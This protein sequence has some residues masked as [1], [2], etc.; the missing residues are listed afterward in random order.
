MIIRVQLKPF[1]EWPGMCGACN[2]TGYE[3]FATLEQMERAGGLWV[4]IDTAKPANTM[5]RSWHTTRESVQRVMD[6]QGT[7]PRMVVTEEDAKRLAFCEHM[8]EPDSFFIGKLFARLHRVGLLKQFPKNQLPVKPADPLVGKFFLSM[9]RCAGCGAS[10]MDGRGEVLERIPGADAYVVQPFAL[11]PNLIRAS[12]VQR[13]Q[14]HEMA[15]W[16][17]YE[18]IPLMLSDEKELEQR[19]HQHELPAHVN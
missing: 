10:R 3:S 9:S 11:G 5:S 13:V 12:G 17:F 6:A 8:I 18:S 2:S 19:S 1:H 14:G 15:F 4:E 7:F 16:N